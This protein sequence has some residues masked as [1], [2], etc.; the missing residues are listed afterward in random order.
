M[1]QEEENSL[2][3]DTDKKAGA[4]IFSYK[5]EIYWPI[6]IYFM[7]QILPCRIWKELFVETSDVDPHWLYADPDPDPRNLMNTDPGQ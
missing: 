5:I 3:K 1:E 2:R 7:D 6:F 4:Y